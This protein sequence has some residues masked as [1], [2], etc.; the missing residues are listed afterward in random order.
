MP[1]SR[2]SVLDICL[3]DLNVL[4]VFIFFPILIFIL[5]IIFQIKRIKEKRL[6]ITM[7][8]ASPAVFA[9][10]YLF[11]II[12][13]FIVGTTSC[14]MSTFYRGIIP[15][16]AIHAQI[17]QRIKENKNIPQ[18]LK[19]LEEMDPANYREMTQYAKVNY[20]FDT[21]TKNYTFFVR[22]SR[23]AIAIFD[24]KRDFK[25]YDFNKIL[26][27]KEDIPTDIVMGTYPPDY[28]GPW[29]KLPK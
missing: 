24:S 1:F 29:D 6:L 10:I 19:D 26:I 16:H 25:I 20:I 11:Y 22:P 8:I 18:Q 21:K 15:A 9:V 13:F 2:Q 7:L 4:G 23:F 17:K 3:N 12:F 28:P 14:S 27:N 5:I